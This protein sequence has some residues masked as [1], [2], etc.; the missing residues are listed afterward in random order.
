[1]YVDMFAHK[2]NVPSQFKLDTFYGQL[3]HVF[4]VRFENPDHPSLRRL[5]AVEEDDNLQSLY[6]VAG[7]HRCSLAKGSPELDN[8]DIHLYS[9][10]GPLDIVDVTAVQ[11]LIGRVPDSEQKWGIIDRSGA[12]ARAIAEEGKGDN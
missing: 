11:C 4:V 5:L 12:L 10:M 3:E 9:N 2:K 8:L 1:M 7:C 6:I